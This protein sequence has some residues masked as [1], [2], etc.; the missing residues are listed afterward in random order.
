MDSVICECFT[1]LGLFVLFS[2][3]FWSLCWSVLFQRS[4]LCQALPPLAPLVPGIDP[5][6]LELALLQ[7]P[8]DPVP[9]A[10]DLV[11]LPVP[12][13]EPVVP[14]VPIAPNVP[15]PVFFVGVEVLSDEEIEI[16]ILN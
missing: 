5:D 14:I 11:D 16:E 15:V 1:I 6:E 3:I 9:E 10:F 4:L 12:V 7:R 2:G 8:G 13:D